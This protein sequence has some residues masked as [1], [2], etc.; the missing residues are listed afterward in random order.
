MPLGPLMVDVQG[1]SLTPEERER[2]C[3]PLVGAVILF[4]RNYASVAQLTALVQSIHA[5]R[6]P[7]L[8]VAVDPE[9]GRVQRFREGFTTL[10]SQARQAPGTGPCLADG[11]GIA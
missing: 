6:E 7:S 2:L 10:Q 8:L 5:L 4:S 1:V 11:H 3:H 9:G